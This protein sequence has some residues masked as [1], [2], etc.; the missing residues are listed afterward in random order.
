MYMENYKMATNNMKYII[1][2]LEKADD[3]TYSYQCPYLALADELGYITPHVIL[4]L[5]SQFERLSTREMLNCSGLDHINS[6]RI[7]RMIE[8]GLPLID[9]ASRLREKYDWYEY[10]DDKGMEVEQNWYSPTEVLYQ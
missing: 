3:K 10:L 8:K 5:P 7:W 6:K 2:A 4:S 1:N 9:I